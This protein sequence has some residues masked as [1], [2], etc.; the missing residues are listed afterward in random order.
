MSY[1]GKYIITGRSK[2]IL[3]KRSARSQKLIN[4]LNL[5][6]NE[7]ITSIACSYNS[8]YL[9]VGQHPGW[10]SILDLKEFCVINNFSPTYTG[11]ESIYSISIFR[12][13]QNVIISSYRGSVGKISWKE[14]TKTETDFEVTK[15]Y[16][17]IGKLTIYDT[18]LT[19][20][21][22]HLIIRSSF[23]VQILNLKM[24][25]IIKE[26]KL[27]NLIVGIALIENNKKTAVVEENGC[28][29]IID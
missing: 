1:D 14:M 12:D 7:N 29:T 5:P 22:E 17:K 6:V 10:L 15:I 24:G 13:N 28:I 26:F 18:Y 20:D 11:Q 2:P 4:T 21:D 9:F 19:N 25:D 3:E 23:H 27:S 8:K 16:D